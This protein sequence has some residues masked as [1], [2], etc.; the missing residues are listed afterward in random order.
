[1]A[2]GIRILSTDGYVDVG[3]MKTCQLVHRETTIAASGSVTVSD[4]DSNSGFIYRRVEANANVNTV[5]GDM[6]W[7]NVTKELSWSG[8]TS[9]DTVDFFLFRTEI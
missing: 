4:F 9:G 7:N 6:N 2:F 3:S 8:H 1:M 5:F